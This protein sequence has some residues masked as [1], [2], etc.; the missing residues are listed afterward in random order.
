MKAYI[1]ENTAK[2]AVKDIQMPEPEENEVLIKVMAAG[3][4]ATD[5][6]IYK[7]EYYSQFP[8]VPGHEF[9]GIIEKTGSKVKYFR[10]GQRVCADPNIY[11]ER[12]EFC[13]NNT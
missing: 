7:G 11:C 4:C 13:K 6:H 9:S 5:G 2:A 12:C 10:K 8:L 3:L 1:I